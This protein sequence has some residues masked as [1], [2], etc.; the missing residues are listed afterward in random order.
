MRIKSAAST[1]IAL[2]LLMGL[3]VPAA[4]AT[5]LPKEDSTDT[6]VINGEEYGP[7]DG[8]RTT[9]ESYDVVGE[10]P[11]DITYA[12]EPEGISPR[13]TWGSSYARSTEYAYVRFQGRAKAAG[14]VYAG[15]RIVGVCIWY[16]H[17]GRKSPTVCSSATSSGRSWSAGPERTVGFTDNLSFNWDKTKFHIRTTRINPSIF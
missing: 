17:P 5:D 1:G 16:A 7:E 10:D 15:E 8:V 4:A 9:T 2:M 6:V 11:I 3:G 14:N 13:A 12:D